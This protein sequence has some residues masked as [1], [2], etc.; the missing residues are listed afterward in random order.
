MGLREEKKERLRREI[1]DTA[2]DLF[3]ERGYD[4]TRV[5]DIIDRV[6]ISE[7]T[8]F[9][10]YPTKDALLDAFAVDS[11]EAYRHLLHG[12][13]QTHERPVPDRLRDLL[14]VMALGFSTDREFMAVVA[15]RSKLFFG[16]E[17][18]I[19]EQE[20]LTYGLLAQL[21]REGQ[22]RSEIRADIHPP[23]LAELFTGTYMLT[24]LNWVVG[25]WEDSEPLE[26][27]L[28]RAADVFLD[29]C[30]P[31]EDAGGGS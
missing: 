11:V 24:I 26:A 13:L 16:A 25:W 28:Q 23:Q 10:Y 3:R 14:R 1:L 27:R 21:F 2:I 9:N 22:E 30:R 6:R 17:G 7:A 20:L 19:L 12:A 4:A 15:T 31:R 18:P 8:F 5:Q 29:G